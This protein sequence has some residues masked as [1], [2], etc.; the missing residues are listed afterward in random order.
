M[1]INGAKPLKKL[2]PKHLKAIELRL[3]GHTNKEVADIMGIAPVTLYTWVADPL[4]KAEEE[5]QRKLI[6]VNAS[7][8]LKQASEM[9]AQTIIDACNGYKKTSV[10]IKA[11]EMV[12]KYS[13]LEP[14]HKI[15]A[16]VNEKV[17]ILDSIPQD[18][19]E[20]E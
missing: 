3:D 6:T 14:V 8:K 7:N 12:L 13:G 18:E 19:D 15:E 16:N 4:F 5:R 9:A 1:A 17:V 20:D 2:M 11:A 10:N